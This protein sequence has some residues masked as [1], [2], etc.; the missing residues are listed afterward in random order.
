MERACLLVCVLV[1]A[2]AG[3]VGQVA[4]MCRPNERFLSCGGCQ[5]TCADPAPACAAV[6]RTGCYCADDHVRNST[7]HCVKLSE[8]PAASAA[9]KQDTT[10][11]RQDCPINEEYRFCEPCNK[12][13]DNPNPMC[14]A[15]CSRGCF[16]KGDLVRDRDGSCVAYE[17]CAKFAK[18]ET[19]NYIK[20]YNLTCAPGQVYKDC[21][22][23]EK[24]CFNPNPICP[25]Q[26]NRGCFCEDGLVK[27]PNGQCVKREDCPKAE[28][29]FGNDPSIEDCAP[30]EEFLSCGWC[31][32]SCWAP[33]PICPG[34]CTRGCLCRPPLVRHYSGHC[35]QQRDCEPQ[36]CTSPNEEYVCRYGCE[37]LC[38]GSNTCPDRPRRC[39]LGCHC[40]IG[41]LRDLTTGQCLTPEQCKNITMTSVPGSKP[42]LP[43][44]FRV[45]VAPN[46]PN[47]LDKVNSASPEN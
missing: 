44:I 23:C 19:S 36:T 35:V 18:N 4:T 32:P 20:P 9:L 24:T 1:C 5:K 30:D 37:I 43:P 41:F 29:T 16:C 11:P 39:Q 13:C 46:P 14:P 3:V 6:C 28:V 7:G 45:R 2:V 21:E 22:P 31:E 40:R 8:C 34:V 26:C 42:D 10:E 27:S 38:G 47:L 25:A 15:Q 12:T 33:S 17:K